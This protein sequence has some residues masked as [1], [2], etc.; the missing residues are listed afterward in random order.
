MANGL[1][2]LHNAKRACTPVVNIIGE[3]ATYHIKYDAPLTT[4]IEAVA[5]PF[6][7]WVKSCPTAEA[8][9]A[10]TREALVAARH[11]PGQ[12]ASLILPADT[13]WTK[14]APAAMA[15]IEIED[16]KVDERAVAEA[17]EVLRGGGPTL[18]L[19]FGEALHEAGLAAAG[20][21]AAA[22]GADLL[23]A[24]FGSR[25]ERG[26]GR[27]PAGPGALSGGPG[28]GAARQVHVRDPGGCQ[29]PGRLFRLSRQAQ[30]PASRRL[31]PSALRRSRL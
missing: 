29:G 8:I 16:K 1:A 24:T 19:L 15:P 20:R 31:P 17:V 26:A 21:I 22:S 13:A 7:G 2:N 11:R 30:P 9:P 25:L 14:A 18:L 5:A 23:A 10:V 3:H 28:G 6:S 27:V 12:V 4:D